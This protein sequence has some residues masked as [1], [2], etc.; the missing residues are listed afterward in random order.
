MTKRFAGMFLVAGA[1]L[2]TP[3]SFVFGS[4]PG[5]RHWT[6][7]LSTARSQLQGASA[8][9]KAFIVGGSMAD[10]YDS[11][12][13]T[14]STLN[15]PAY[16]G[17][18]V[19]ITSSGDLVAFAGGYVGSHVYTD[20]VDIYNASA[21]TWDIGALSVGRS[22]MASVAVQDK[23]IFAGGLGG[24][25]WCGQNSRHLRH[26]HGCVVC[27]TVAEYERRCSRRCCW[28]QGVLRG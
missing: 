6:E 24:G 9:G 26:F 12:S 23:I 27:N 13:D 15:L 21:G 1:I 25:R 22:R 10:V 19:S 18:N 4:P 2:A 14:W 11:G 5:V 3:G 16:H 7:S 20:R 8:A 28:L 17:S